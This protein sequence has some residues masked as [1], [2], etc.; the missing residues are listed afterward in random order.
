MDPL[1]CLDVPA[2]P[3]Q[4]L[5]RRHPDWRDHPVAVVAEDKPTARILWVNEASRQRRILSGMR[6]AAGLTLDREL[7][8]GVVSPSE[9]R[10]EVDR[11]AELLRAFTPEVEPAADEPGVFWLGASGLKLLHPS[12]EQWASLIRTRVREVGLWSE[13]AVGFSRFAV[14]AAARAA[15][16]PCL[17]FGEPEDERRCLRCLA[18]D[19]LGFEPRL[20]DTL[21]KLG[22]HTLGGFLDLPPQGIRRRFGAEAF[23]LYQ[24]AR[25]ELW[26]PLRAQIPDDPVADRVHFDQPIRNRDRLLAATSRLLGPLLERVQEQGWELAALECELVFDPAPGKTESTR[27]TERLRPARPTTNDAQILELVRLRF[28]ATRFPTGVVELG[29]LIEPV[30][31]DRGQSQLFEERSQRDLDAAN[32]AL[33]QLRAEFGDPAVTVARL[34]D[35]HLPEA[36][37]QWQPLDRLEAPR[38]RQVKMRPLVRRIFT[39]PQPLPH[40]GR[41]EPDGWLIK[42]LEGRAVE[43]TVGPFVISG[44]WWRRDV[45]REYHFARTQ[46]GTWLWIYYDRERRRWMQQGS[47]E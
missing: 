16:D 45:H 29:L 7:R 31:A 18:I 3:L 42:G 27:T 21:A 10:E 20:R 14:Y 47:V 6:Y 24:L 19:R 5:L 32:R 4:L 46:A 22:I 1:A 2:F 15:K 35:G 40:R 13:I 11:L 41:H 17:V 9:I 25:D 33:A 12:Y 28:E 8:A 39:R 26:R 30:S 34:R 43:E 23:E 38:P 37:F 44:G 36:R